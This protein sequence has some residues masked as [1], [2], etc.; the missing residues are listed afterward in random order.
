MN[1][2]LPSVC[3]VRFCVDGLFVTYQVTCADDVSPELIKA[4][5]NYAD[6]AARLNYVSYR[7]SSLP[8]PR[9]AVNKCL[10][11]RGLLPVNVEL[12]VKLDNGPHMRVE[13]K[14]TWKLEGDNKSSILHWDKMSTARDMKILSPDE[15]F[16]TPIKQAKNH[17]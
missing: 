2:R 17:R 4:Y 9:L 16:G 3:L 6:W 14:F 12:Q 13:H 7:T 11:R 15:F 10:L 5:L 8:D 1:E